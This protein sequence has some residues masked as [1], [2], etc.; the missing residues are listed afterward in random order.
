MS[1]FDISNVLSDVSSFS[2]NGQNTEKSSYRYLYPGIGTLRVKLLY[3]PKSDTFGRITKKHVS[4]Q[5]KAICLSMYHQDC[6]VCKMIESIKNVTGQDDWKLKARVRA[7]TFAQYVG[8][9][10]YTWTK[11]NPEPNQGDIVILM[12][13]WTVYQDICRLLVNCGSNAEQLIATNIGKV[14]NI[15]RWQ[16]NSQTKYK[17][18]IDAFAPDYKSADTEEAFRDMLN[19]LPSL[20]ETSCPP[21]ITEEMVKH[22]NEMAESLSRQYL[23]AYH[24]SPAIQASNVY[25]SKNDINT[26]TYQAPKD[27]M[28][29]PNVTQSQN[30]PHQVKEAPLPCIGQYSDS[31]PKCIACLKSVACKMISS[32]EAPF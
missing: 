9:N 26:T 28:P 27:T 11:D 32:D 6:P 16:E 4:G 5:T 22:A 1:Y 14:V 17:C 20:N 15:S 19:N 18:E 13:P 2:Q 10:N 3:N 7:I 30:P 21:E 8:C 25:Q 12:Y 23:R 29:A 24:S 31:N